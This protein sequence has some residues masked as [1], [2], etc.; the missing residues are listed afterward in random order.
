MSWT[1][2]RINRTCN[3][4]AKCHLQFFCFLYYCCR[5]HWCCHFLLPFLPVAVFTC[6]RFFR[7]PFYRCRFFRE[8]LLLLLST[9]GWRD[10]VW[11][12]KAAAD[13]PRQWTTFWTSESLPYASFR[14]VL[15]VHLII[16]CTYWHQHPTTTCSVAVDA[17][18]SHHWHFLKVYHC[19]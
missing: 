15:F 16:A 11:A 19:I 2:R 4:V 3:L 7:C 8:S 10:Y 1:E 6:C 17:L 14:P 9:R 5:F 13:S 12:P 18:K